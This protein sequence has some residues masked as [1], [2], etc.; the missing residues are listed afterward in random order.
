MSTLLSC[1]Q[2]DVQVHSCVLVEKLTLELKAGEL[3]AVLGRNG[4]GKSLTLHT[5]AGLRDV[6]QGDIRLDDKPLSQLHRRDIA[7][8]VAFV[9]QEIEEPFPV[10]V[11]EAALNGRHPHIDFWHWE[12]PRDHAIARE[13]LA[14]VDLAAFEARSIETLSGGERRRLAIA[15]ALAQQPRLFILDEPTNHLDPAHQLQV[16]RLLR[17][18]AS[19][20]C[21][22]L[23][24]LHDPGLAARFADKVLLLFGNGRWLY[25]PPDEMLNA[26]TLSALY[27]APMHEQ[28]SEHGRN[29]IAV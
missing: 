14:T 15:A 7:R 19:T 4:T 13:A 18:R 24:S 11:L 28:R 26:D 8:L 9:P 5:L 3:T 12:S 23:L 17:E 21:A 22:A 2:L 29:F 20:G 25:G 10:T 6:S 27:L 16:L 1:H